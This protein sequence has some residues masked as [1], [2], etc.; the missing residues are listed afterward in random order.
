MALLNPPEILPHLLEVIH[1]CLRGAEQQA[2][3]RETLVRLL[4]PSSLGQGEEGQPGSRTLSRTL[5]ACRT[6]G[7]LFEERPGS[8]GQIMVHLNAEVRAD[9][10]NGRGGRQFRAAL[11][12]LVLDEALNGE[13]WEESDGG[14]SQEGARDLTRA[15]SWFLTQDVFGPPLWYEDAEASRSVDRLQSRQLTAE[16]R[17]IINDNR[18]QSFARWAPYLGFARPVVLRE[19]DYLVPDP[20]PAVV[21]AVAAIAEDSGAGTVDLRSFLDRLAAILP[22]VDSGRYRRAVEERMV[23]SPKS[24]ALP[25]GTLSSSLATALL[26]L[27]DQKVL[28][29][30]NKA[31]YPQKTLFPDETGQLTPY[32]HVTITNPGG[33]YDRDR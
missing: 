28:E 16:D 23:T 15:L 3:E 22:V 12:V 13:L 27:Q 19:R 29:L 9:G 18:W 33:T 17:V 25:E 10:R 11:R 6:N 7:L 30:I 14:P 8:D 20:T 32:S 2:M 31:D 4:A 21:D 26:R 1:R 5:T 24:Q